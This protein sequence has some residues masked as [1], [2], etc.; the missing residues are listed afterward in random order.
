M[1][2]AYEL[3]NPRRGLQSSVVLR[4]GEPMSYSVLFQSAA[5]EALTLEL[6]RALQSL[7]VSVVPLDTPASTELGADVPLVT[8]GRHPTELGH[9]P[10]PRPWIGVVPPDEGSPQPFL[11]R[12]ASVVLRWPVER[13]ELLSVVARYL[14]KGATAPDD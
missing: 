6:V 7:R 13:A 14:A 9:L 2:M 1:L 11:E 3:C 10:L 8:V 4:A 5:P 12:G